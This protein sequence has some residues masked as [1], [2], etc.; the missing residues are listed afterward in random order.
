VFTADNNRMD[1]IW[2]RALCGCT[3]Q[4]HTTPLY[5]SFNAGGYMAARTRSNI[6]DAIYKILVQSK[7]M[8]PD[9]L[10]RTIVA[11]VQ[12]FGPPEYCEQCEHFDLSRKVYSVECY[13]C[14][15]YYGDLF[16]LRARA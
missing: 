8:Y 1:A 9:S 5:K 4:H 15:Q 13:S 3:K 14:K 10:C 16:T 12:S 2:G 6:E 11:K 7:G